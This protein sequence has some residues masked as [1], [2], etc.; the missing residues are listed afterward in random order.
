MHPAP[1]GRDSIAKRIRQESG[2]GSTR[3]PQSFAGGI[4]TWAIAA[5]IVAGTSAT[6]NGDST[7]AGVGSYQ[8]RP[9][10][11]TTR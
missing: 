7:D 4:A 8:P 9:I 3:H 6:D 1:G 2:T 5:G 10:V 11:E